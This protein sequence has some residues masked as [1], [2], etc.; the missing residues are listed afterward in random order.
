MRHVCIA[1][2]MTFVLSGVSIGGDEVT[3]LILKD[4]ATLSILDA[5]PCTYIADETMRIDTLK[6]SHVHRLAINETNSVQASEF[7]LKAANSLYAFELTRKNASA[8]WVIGRVVVA[9][10]KEN[11][12]SREFQKMY[13]VNLYFPLSAFYTSTCH[14]ALKSGELVLSKIEQAGVHKLVAFKYRT[15]LSKLPGK[16]EEFS[17]TM[18]LDPAM[19]HA[20]IE[21]TI[22]RDRM[23]S[24]PASKQIKMAKKYEMR[25]ERPVAITVV[26]DTLDGH[27][28]STYTYSDISFS[29]KDR[30]KCTLSDYGFP[31]PVGIDKLDASLPP[32][33]SA[34]NAATVGSNTKYF[35]LAA[36]VL[37]AMAAI[38]AM[39]AARGRKSK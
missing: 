13:N 35:V 19:R 37:M 12:L 4:W 2:L 11:S 16:E 21:C 32:E 5:Q 31:E 9:K 38:F 23:P 17:G 10:P 39:V 25:N 15:S 7:K 24:T 14:D 34:T 33:S 36:C 28:V 8:E 18:L 3:D 1:I 22:T 26:Y 27:E 29:S 30:L 6:K 20:V